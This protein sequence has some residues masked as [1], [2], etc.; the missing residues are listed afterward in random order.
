MLR[1]LRS[2]LNSVSFKLNSFSYQTYVRL[3]RTLNRQSGIS[4]NSGEPY[5]V[6]SLTS[7]PPRFNK[8]PLVLES[9]CQQSKKPDKILLWLSEDHKAKGLGKLTMEDIP[10]KILEYESRGVEIVFTED[11][12]SYRKLIPTLERYPDSA[13]VTVDDDILF[14]RSAIK[15]LFSAHQSNPDL[16]ISL[17]SRTLERQSSR[18]LSPYSEWTLNEHS[19]I[20]GLSVFFT[21]GSGVLFPP[22]IFE[23][24][25][26]EKERFLELAP[27]SDDIWFN[28]MRLK[29]EVQTLSLGRKHYVFMHKVSPGALSEINWGAGQNDIQLKRVFDNYN[30]YEKIRNQV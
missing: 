2:L 24:E 3:L 14:K 12:G 8:L 29:G 13:I 6:V 16:I 22:R 30:L 9:L 5:L 18:E 20:R 4:R 11:I 10:Q 19:A 1:S 17:R 28:A 25:I 27:H 15:D 23:N 21:T 7:I 26:H